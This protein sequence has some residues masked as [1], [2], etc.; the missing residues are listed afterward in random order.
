MEFEKMKKIWD[1]QNNEPLYAINEKALHKRIHSKQKRAGHIANFSELL[2]IFVNF[3][4]GFFVLAVSLFKQSGNLFMYLL[5]AWMFV[6]AFYVLTR[7][8]RRIKEEHRFDRSMLG[9]LNHAISNAT[10]QVRLSLIMRW[11]I[12]P[13]GILMILGFWESGKAVWI[14]VPTLI[15]IAFVHFASGWEHNIYKTRKR[16]LEIL[17][18]KLQEEEISTEH[19]S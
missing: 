6:T 12:L 8:L 17:Q 7:R 14:I 13:V 15:F 5:A 18:K 1:T 4:A 3:G 11:N 19:S 16:K 10:Y 2:T 9:D